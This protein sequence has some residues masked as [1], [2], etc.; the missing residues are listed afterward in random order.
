MQGCIGGWGGVGWG[1]VGLGGTMP[2]LFEI[3]IIY[4]NITNSS[5]FILACLIRPI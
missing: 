1:G 3:K 2:A 5:Q 4:D